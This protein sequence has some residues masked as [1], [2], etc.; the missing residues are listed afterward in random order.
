MKYFYNENVKSVSDCNKGAFV[1]E[2]GNV[3]EQT[4]KP[5]SEFH[6]MDK[7]GRISETGY[8]KI[9]LENHAGLHRCDGFFV[10]EKDGINYLLDT[11]SNIIARGFE[12]VDEF[13]E[14]GLAGINFEDRN[15][16][17]NK[18]GVLFGEEFE[19]VYSFENNLSVAKL[20]NEKFVYVNSELKIISPEFDM[21]YLTDSDKYF[22]VQVGEELQVVDANFN[23]LYEAPENIIFLNNYGY[24]YVLKTNQETEK[25]F[26]IYNNFGKHV[27]S[28]DLISHSNNKLVRF[29]SDGRTWYINQETGKILGG[30]NGYYSGEDFNGEYAIIG[31]GLDYKGE[32][33]YGIID[34]NGERKFG[35]YESAFWAEKNL[36][37]VYVL[38]AK[39]THGKYHLLNENGEIEKKGF[40]RLN[41][42]HD[43]LASFES[44]KNKYSFVD[45]FGKRFIN[46]YDSVKPFNCGFAVVKN[47]NIPDVI[48]KNGISLRKISEFMQKI[49]DDPHSAF[50][51]PSEFLE[52]INLVLE[53]QSFIIN[54]LNSLLEI[55]D[56]E[57]L[58]S[59][60]KK[61]ISEVNSKFEKMILDLKQK[62]N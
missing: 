15:F 54:G 40:A 56:L 42:F 33:V 51:F 12:S 6:I 45:K 43:G 62:S 14:S 18:Q 13:N 47:A 38:N 3:N 17:I 36:L 16:W 52:D 20:K 29:Y 28:A 27:C 21:A 11:E 10:A 41:S 22:L 35:R 26:Q 48:N 53:I 46:D 8:E 24:S 5:F 32:H 39:G 37:A 4:G 59:E 30:K 7:F 50:D 1:V 31:L 23:K 9:N 19:N 57:S 49:E 2:I 34:E 58:K 61:V 44:S 55:K 25:R 60:I